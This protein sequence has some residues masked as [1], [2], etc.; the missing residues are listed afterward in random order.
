MWPLFHP[1]SHRPW[2]LYLFLVINHSFPQ[3]L[4]IH[5]LHC[6]HARSQYSLYTFLVKTSKTYSSSC[7]LHVSSWISVSMVYAIL[8]SHKNLQRKTHGA[9]IPFWIHYNLSLQ[10]SILHVG[11][12]SL[13]MNK[14]QSVSCMSILDLRRKFEYTVCTKIDFGHACIPYN[15]AILYTILKSSNRRTNSNTLL[16]TVIN[17]LDWT[18]LS[19]YIPQYD[20]NVST[21]TT[22]MTRMKS[23]F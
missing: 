2:P 21:R 11:L 15:N 13:T 5:N 12:L 6:L 20:G 18:S 3:S 14:W 1:G 19:S 9:R 17:S 22:D 8:W 16:N 7:S 23:L 10:L 4:Q